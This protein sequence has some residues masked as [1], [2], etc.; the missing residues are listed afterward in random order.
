MI[1]H[2]SIGDF[3]SSATIAM[4]PSLKA[5]PF[6]IARG[7]S[8]RALVL[9][10]SPTARKEG[11]RVGMRLA[12][13]QLI[14]PSLLVIEPDYRALLRAREAIDTVAG[15]YSPNVAVT[16]NGSFFL[17]M[18]GTTRLF[19]PVVDSAARL[20]SEI[21]SSLGFDGSVAVASNTL[22]ANVA[23][24]TIAPS[25]L[26]SIPPGE[27][28]SF[29]HPQPVTLLPGVGAKIASLLHSVNIIHIG[30]LA[31]LDEKQVRSFL[32]PK[33]L[34]LYKRAQ[35]V[36]P[37]EG[38]VPTEAMIERRVRFS[39][40]LIDYPLIK[41]ALR[42]TCEESGFELRTR[43]LAARTLSLTLQWID[44]M[45]R[46]RS[47][48]LANPIV[49]DTQIADHAEILLQALLTRR[50]HVLGCT[51][52]LSRLEPEIQT[53]D[54][55]DAEQEMKRQNLQAAVDRIR[56][57]YGVESLSISGVFHGK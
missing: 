34:E 7:S 19:G 22:V 49:L 52:R 24:Q 35:G 29:L 17:D 50:P 44:G 31:G 1:I 9:S 53:I 10:P 55:F 39:E 8:A 5:V 23:T 56:S 38:P 47:M 41:A 26:A 32:G 11:I 36:M 13:A 6:V 42:S 16:K 27:E 43:G 12:H 45:E 51:F 21:H 15:R 33:G 2:L 20:R 54:L 30:D 37:N 3:S 46:T 28:S 25:G 57:R 14:L 40:P 48:T 18:R 4:N